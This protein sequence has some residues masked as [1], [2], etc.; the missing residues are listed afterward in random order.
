MK[1]LFRAEMLSSNYPK[2]ENECFKLIDNTWY[3]IGKD[4][5]VE[6]FEHEGIKLCSILN[7]YGA[8]LG[9][10]NTKAIHFEDMLDSDNNPIFASLSENGK[11]GDMF[12]FDNEVFIIW[13]DTQSLKI[14]ATNK[15]NFDCNCHD[16]LQEWFAFENKCY[17]LKV[18]GIQK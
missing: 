8:W 15:D 5:T 6:Y 1:I 11:G 4:S 2:K 10:E 17:D 12:L 14:N 13:L 18:I 9:K 7:K 16:L 3:V